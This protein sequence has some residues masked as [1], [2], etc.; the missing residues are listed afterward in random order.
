MFLRLQFVHPVKMINLTVI[1]IPPMPTKV[2]RAKRAEAELHRMMIDIIHKLAPELYQRAQ[3][4]RITVSKCRKYADI[5][6][7]GEEQEVIVALDKHVWKM[8]KM[9]ADTKQLRN[10]PQL[11]FR[12]DE[13]LAREIRIARLLGRDL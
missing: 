3:I 13:E 6:M 5:H 1:F 7:T 11:R 2:P 4:S 8:K 9:L 12:I 10:I